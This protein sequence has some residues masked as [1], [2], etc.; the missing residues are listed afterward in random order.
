MIKIVTWLL[1]FST[2]IIGVY[3]T[4]KLTEYFAKVLL[5]V[6]GILVSVLA[7]FTA[8]LYGGYATWNWAIVDRIA[9]DYAM[10]L[11]AS[12]PR[13]TG[14]LNSRVNR[15][16]FSAMMRLHCAHSALTNCASQGVHYLVLLCSLRWA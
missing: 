8:L 3:A 2:T 13:R 4:G 6:L 16:R 14:S 9:K 7:A 1:G 15:R 11:P 12:I 5:I 10:D